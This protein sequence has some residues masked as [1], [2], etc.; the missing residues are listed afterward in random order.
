MTGDGGI[1][2]HALNLS[3]AKGVMSMACCRT[4]RVRETP[5]PKPRL[6]LSQRGFSLPTMAASLSLS[7]TLSGW[8]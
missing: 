8:R 2:W 4:R 1:S 3:E 6:P 7:E 5:V